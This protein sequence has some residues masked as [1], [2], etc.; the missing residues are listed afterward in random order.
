MLVSAL[1]IA[2]QWRKRF[3][4]AFTGGRESPSFQEWPKFASTRPT[5][6]PSKSAKHMLSSWIVLGFTNHGNLLRDPVD[7]GRKDASGFTLFRML[8]DKKLKGQ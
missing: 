6:Q 5:L 3:L 1:V 7:V 2:P 8:V 4:K